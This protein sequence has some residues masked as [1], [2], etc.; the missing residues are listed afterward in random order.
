MSE[1][2]FSDSPAPSRPARPKMHTNFPAFGSHFQSHKSSDSTHI[3][4]KN[5]PKVPLISERTLN[6]NR[7]DTMKKKGLTDKENTNRVTRSPEVVA[8][9]IIPALERLKRENRPQ[10]LG[11]PGVHRP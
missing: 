7:E 4:V 3:T 9:A 8:H 10:V 6:K 1:A 11:Q 2:E 5:L